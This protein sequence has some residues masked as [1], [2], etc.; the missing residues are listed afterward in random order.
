[1]KVVVLG[2]KGMLGHVVAR[3][4]KEKNVDVITTDYRWPT[5]EFRDFISS[6]EADDVV[7]CIGQT[8]QKDKNPEKLFL[9]NFALP[10]YLSRFCKVHLTH[11]TTDCEF[12][13]MDNPESDYRSWHS[14]DAKDDYGVS[15]SAA[16]HELFRRH[17]TTII[18]T[19]I[20]GP[21]LSSKKSLWEWFINAPEKNVKGFVSHLW[22]GITTLEW[23]ETYYRL[24]LNQPEK[25]RFLQVGCDAVSKYDILCMINKELKRGKKIIRWDGPIV[26]K[27]LH[28]EVRVK[29]LDFQIKEMVSWYYPIA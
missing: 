20:I 11:A 23:A 19:S 9:N 3:F 15:K 16:T 25:T 27:T 8:P 14:P 13:G 5:R 2:H 24:I 29:P 26:N 17:N 12:A 21:E 4:L 22:N 28:P 7:N 1:M 18:R 10:I 6:V